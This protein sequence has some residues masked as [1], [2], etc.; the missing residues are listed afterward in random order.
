MFGRSVS[1]KNTRGLVVRVTMAYNKQGGF[2]NPDAKPYDAKGERRME[3][4]YDNRVWGGQFSNV[5]SH[6]NYGNFPTHDGSYPYESRG[7]YRGRSRGQRNRY[8]S[9]QG[10][11]YLDS[12]NVDSDQ[13]RQQRVQPYQSDSPKYNRNQGYG[14]Q[15][16]SGPSQGDSQKGDMAQRNSMK[17]G[18]DQGNRQEAKPDSY[19]AHSQEGRGGLQDHGQGAGP[20]SDQAHS[21]EGRVMVQDDGQGAGPISYQAHSQ[22]GRGVVQDHGQRAGPI[23]YQGHSQENI[24]RGQHNE[25]NARQ[26]LQ[27]AYD[28]KD[29]QKGTEGIRAFEQGIEPG[30]CKGDFQNVQPILDQNVSQKGNEGDH[31]QGAPP[32]CNNGNLKE[33]NDMGQPHGN[34]SIQR[35]QSASHENDLQKSNIWGKCHEK[36][37]GQSNTLGPNQGSWRRGETSSGGHHQDNKTHQ[38]QGGSYGRQSSSGGGFR[39]GYQ[40]QDGSYG[41]Q[42][43]S[44]GGFRGGYQ[45]QDGSYGTQSSSGGGSRGGNFDQQQRT[46]HSYQGQDGSYGR[47]SSSGGGSRGDNFDQQQRTRNRAEDEDDIFLSKTLSFLLRHGAEKMKFKLMPGGFL[48]VDEILKK[49]KKLEGY[50]V[51]DVQR[52]VAQND[53]QRFALQK[54][55]GTNRLKIRANQGHTV[56]VENLELTPITSADQVPMV[57]HGT[58]FDAWN[59]IKKQGLCR[60]KR[61]HIHFAAGEPGENGVISGMRSSCEV[62]IYIDLEKALKDGLKFYLSA[63]RVILSPGNEEGYIYPCYFKVVLKRHP[64]HIL[65]FDPN[66]KGKTVSA[67]QTSNELDKKIKRKNKNKN[68]KKNKDKENFESK[69]PGEEIEG[70][71]DTDLFAD[72]GEKL[73]EENIEGKDEEDQFVDAIDTEPEKQIQVP[74]VWDDAEKVEPDQKALTNSK[75]AEQSEGTQG[76]SESKDPK[77]TK[78]SKTT[79]KDS[80]TETSKGASKFEAQSRSQAPK[81][82]TK[83]EIPKGSVIPEGEQNAIEKGPIPGDEN[84]EA[85][86]GAED[87]EDVKVEEEWTTV[88]IT[89]VEESQSA[90]EYILEHKQNEPVSIICCGEKQG[91]ADGTITLLVIS[92]QNKSWIYQLCNMTEDVM[93]AG[94]LKQLFFDT[95][96]MKACIP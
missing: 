5:G 72:E 20:I 84:E 73:K 24:D 22:E 69:A 77:E 4:S 32:S 59:S 13:N 85:P 25:N 90:V 48:Y 54:E 93:K 28:Q 33:G 10:Q 26:E 65:E 71:G 12:K 79:E 1:L 35:T 92:M 44:G 58:Y 46:T 18:M 14:Q 88:S 36:D 67:D 6:Q 70:V 53:K 63:N 68:K 80:R 61:N 78:E 57:L 96:L 41:R 37:S 55:D 50:T 40:G 2:Q 8:G 21:Q 31:V 74:D 7:N 51:E 29:S 82:A 19:Q 47:Q 56:E 94:K 11:S 81:G 64:Y 15:A 66:I 43:S 60:F 17:S 49:M 39:G 30:S 27:T 42:S 91:D 38:G 16:Q 23:S 62:L 52:I 45:G 87:E 3:A 76:L 95:E 9:Q 86:N 83:P 89:S 34:D 75:R